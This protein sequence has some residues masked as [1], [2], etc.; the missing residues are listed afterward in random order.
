SDT[1][2]IYFNTA[3]ENKSADIGGSIEKIV[4]RGNVKIVRGE[5]ISYSQEATYSAADQKVVLTGRP[6]LVIYSTEGLHASP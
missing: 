4:A 1:M 3:K 2:D 6:K 5:N